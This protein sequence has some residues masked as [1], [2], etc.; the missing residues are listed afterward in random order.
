[1]QVPAGTFTN[2]LK[3]VL[4]ITDG[5][6]DTT[7]ISNIYYARKIGEILNEGWGSWSGNYRFSLLSYQVTSVAEH[8]TDKYPR[9]FLLQQNYPNPFNPTTA[10][11]YQIPAAGLV[12][13]QL[14]DV[15]GHAVRSLVNEEQNARAYRVIW[16]GRNDHGEEVAGGIY[17]YRLTTGQNTKTM[18]L[19]L[20]K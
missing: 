15:L 10:I 12:S 4:I 3:V 18:K 9:D 6:G 19:L 13:L 17:F 20:L 5:S 7:Q 16:N 2:C 8:P 14:F 1:V 11:D